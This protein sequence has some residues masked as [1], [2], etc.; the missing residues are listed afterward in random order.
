MLAGPA[1]LSL[2]GPG[3]EGPFGGIA[4]FVTGEPEQVPGVHPEQSR[5]WRRGHLLEGSVI[6]PAVHGGGG[7]GIGGRESDGSHD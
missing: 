7:Y 6:S 3:D 1:G 5:R 4:R 2:D